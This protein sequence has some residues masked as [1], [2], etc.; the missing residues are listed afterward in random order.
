MDIFSLGVVLFVM[1]VGR[2][3]YSLKQCETLDYA[4]IRLEDAPGLLDPRCV[5][6]CACV[7]KALAFAFAWHLL[8]FL[9]ERVFLVSCLCVCLRACVCA[10]VP[11]WVPVQPRDPLCVPLQ[12]F[13]CMCP[14]AQV[15]PPHVSGPVIRHAA[16]P[17]L[18]SLTGPSSVWIK[19]RPNSK[20][21]EAC[22]GGCSCRRV[23]RTWSCA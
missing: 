9:C 22:A 17:Q 16:A 11:V 7:R 3:P 23:P 5:C 4:R 2:K 8:V 15:F 20:S 1:L 19:V 6:A 12:C 21:P 13:A 10:R 14:R 18:S